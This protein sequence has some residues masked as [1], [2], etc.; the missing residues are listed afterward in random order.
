M[1]SFHGLLHGLPCIIEE[2]FC[3]FVLVHV[4]NLSTPATTS[5]FTLFADKGSIL[6]Q[7]KPIPPRISCCRLS[8][9][10]QGSTSLLV[11]KSPAFQLDLNTQC[12]S[13]SAKSRTK[14]A[15]PV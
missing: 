1:H 5:P 7:I 12:Q 10:Q 2:Q 4:T 14:G 3:V 9:E 11:S 6:I 15:D 13:I 8:K